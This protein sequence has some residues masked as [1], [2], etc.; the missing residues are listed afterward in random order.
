MKDES[1]PIL[2]GIDAYYPP[3]EIASL[4]EETGV[5][6]A[7]LSFHK[8]FALGLHAGAYIS[9]GALFFTL[10]T[11]GSDLGFGP[12][13]MLGGI[14][15][16]LGL[17]LVVVGGAELFT[18]NNLIVMAWAERRITTG[19]ILRNWAIV[20]VS[21]F[22]GCMAILVCCY[23]SGLYA[24]GD[25]AFAETTRAIATS[26]VEHTFVEDFFLGILCNVLVC[27]ASWL[28]YGAR[29]VTGKILAVTFPV[30][31]FVALGFQHSIA[32]MYLIPAGM[33]AGAEGITLLSLAGNL[34]PVTLGNIVGGGG[35]VAL[36][37][38]V[39]YLREERS[40]DS[41]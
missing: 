20:Y 19:Q 16:S 31:A 32:N 4:V 36:I 9:F 21:N 11:T 12:T 40:S 2:T 34:I 7:R 39:I 25:G 18:G 35:L 10:I 37:Y 29:T 23:L 5:K 41:G 28:S 15:F 22:F 38:W 6:K 1:G 33:L 26:K 30:S 13:K 24:L 3:Q 17:V 27:L 14:A 8:T